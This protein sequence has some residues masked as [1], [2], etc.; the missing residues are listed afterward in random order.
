M[1]DLPD[2]YSMVTELEAEAY[3]FRGGADASKSEA[4]EA[5]DVYFATDTKI[6]YICVVDGSWTGFDASILVQGILTLY[7]NVVA[8]GYR[9][10]GLGAP[11][12]DNDAARKVYVDTLHALCLLLT[13]G[14][15]SGDIAMGGNK[16]TGLGAPTAANDAVRKAYA[17]LFIL[18]SLLT[19]EGDLIVRGDTVP[20][21]FAKP[22]TG[23]YLRATATGYEGATLTTR[24]IATG[25]YTGD[26][27]TDRQ[28]TTGFKCSLV[29]VINFTGSIK[30]CW[31]AIPSITGRAATTIDRTAEVSLHATDGIVV[32]EAGTDAGNE[33][34][35]VYYY[36]AIS[37]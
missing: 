33:S 2:W 26:D 35:E 27:A 37:E 1:P 29:I 22:T 21:R 13:G 28:I 12:A 36:W 31:I 25:N 16:V 3:K 14:T 7:A 6:L 9:I 18:K 34:G 11:T 15:M 8:G 23:Q 17:D 19:T 20:E 10:T 32:G 4:P 24:T 30:G 5:R